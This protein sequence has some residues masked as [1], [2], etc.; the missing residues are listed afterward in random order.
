MFHIE[1]EC[2]MLA[3]RNSFSPKDTHLAFYAFVVFRPKLGYISEG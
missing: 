1:E 3:L 2:I